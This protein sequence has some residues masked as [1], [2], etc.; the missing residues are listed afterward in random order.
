MEDTQ[1]AKGADCKLLAQPSMVQIHL[2]HFILQKKR[3]VDK[4]YIS[5]TFLIIYGLIF[6]QGVILSA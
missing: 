3:V 6:R 2:H 5:T 1:A 4:I